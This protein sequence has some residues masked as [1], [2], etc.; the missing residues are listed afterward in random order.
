MMRGVSRLRPSSWLLVSLL[1]ILGVASAESAPMVRVLLA[2]SEALTVTF[3]G[4]HAGALDGV[5]FATSVA[6]AWPIA[7][8]EGALVIDGVAVGRELE[9][10]SAE[11]V[12]WNGVRY[13]GSLRLIADAERILVV[14]VL[15]LENYLRG[16]VPAEMQA[17]WHAE[18]LKAQAVAA[19]TYTLRYLRP[20]APYDICATIDCQVYAGVAAE[21][22]GSDA[23]VAATAGEVLTYD[24]DLARVY[25][26]SDSGGAT[27]SASEVW[28]YD[29]PYLPAR[30]DVATRSPHAQWSARID[31]RFAAAWLAT[32]GIDIGLL[33]SLRVVATSA[34]GRVV[35]AEL[36]GARGR[37]VLDGAVLRTQ[38]R[39]WGLRSTRFEMTGALS[40]RGQGWG[41][42][43]GMSQ[44]GALA[45]A[46][47][48]RDYRSI[49]ATYYPGTLLESVAALA[50]RAT[51]LAQTP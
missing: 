1:W 18:A 36:V 32:V 47:S 33:E 45:M 11:G 48:G 51:A 2:H 21:H 30:S 38:L 41:H 9:L 23:A 3:A 10:R 28:G 27:A 19:R 24:G 7:H 29:L 20:D 50:E 14:N 17:S 5:P 12:T 26:H 16:V 6:L 13:R 25:Y 44:Y 4:P 37:V 43:V 39:G 46:E 8:A 42:G 22:P 34:S 35:R 15:D 49:L 40:V 31:P